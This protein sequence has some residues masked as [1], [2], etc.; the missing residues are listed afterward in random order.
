[1]TKKK[2]NLG[3]NPK[4]VWIL[5]Y[6]LIIFLPLVLVLTEVSSHFSKGLGIA[7]EFLFTIIFPATLPYACYFAL[8][9]SECPNCKKNYYSKNVLKAAFGQTDECA[10]CGKKA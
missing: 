4:R 10:T 5:R 1:M 3:I 9:K 7:E 8:L 6:A 2:N